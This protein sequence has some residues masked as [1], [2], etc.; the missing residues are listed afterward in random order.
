MLNLLM[1]SE[2]KLCHVRDRCVVHVDVK[3]IRHGHIRH[4]DIVSISNLATLSAS[5]EK[6]C[7]KGP[8]LVILNLIIHILA[9]VH[10]PTLLPAILYC[11]LAMALQI[12][13]IT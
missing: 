6:A 10:D 11:L 3:L 12:L 4:D 2:V 5:F 9:A 13:A 1:Q 8:T 7:R